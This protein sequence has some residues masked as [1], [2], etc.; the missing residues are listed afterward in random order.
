MTDILG[1]PI[2]GDVD[3]GYTRKAIEQW[4]AARLIADIDALFAADPR[5]SAIQWRQYTPYFNDGD[6]CEFGA[7]LNDEGFVA[8]DKVPTYWHYDEATDEEGEPVQTLGSYG[9]DS[10]GTKVYDY[11]ARAFVEKANPTPLDIA[12]QQLEDNWNHYEAV[13]REHFGEHA[14]V[15]A[16]REGFNVEYYEHD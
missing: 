10:L 4:D 7:H 13:V 1:R 9:A 15:I 8:L 3:K 14:V 2:T 12:A 11:N 16:T 5:V 6:P